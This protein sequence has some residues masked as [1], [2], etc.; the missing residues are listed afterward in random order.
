MT[1]RRVIGGVALALTVISPRI[2]AQPRPTVVVLDTT[3]QPRMMFEPR[4]AVIASPER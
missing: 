2:Q 4:A 1:P 3:G